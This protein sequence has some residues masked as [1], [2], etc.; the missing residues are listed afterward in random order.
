MLDPSEA[1]VTIIDLDSSIECRTGSIRLA[2]RTTIGLFVRGRVEVCVN[3]T[4]TTVCNVGWD[5]R[6][7]V[8]A[9]NQLQL[10]SYG[11]TKKH[12]EVLI[13]KLNCC[14]HPRSICAWW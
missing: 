11:K 5:Y 7:A 14:I 13:N 3:K 1:R 12:I 4:W 6:D 10:P 8:V 9:C 2:D